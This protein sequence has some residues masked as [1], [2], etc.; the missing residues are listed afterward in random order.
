MVEATRAGGRTRG[1]ALGAGGLAIGLILLALALRGVDLDNLKSALLHARFVWLLPLVG[2]ALLS[3]LIRAWRWNLIIRAMPTEGGRPPRLGES[4]GVVM[5]GYMV[6]YVVPR[7]GEVARAGLL[8]R[9]TRLPFVGVAGTVAAER[10]FDT[11]SLGVALVITAFLLR[12]RIADVLGIF[13]RAGASTG[14]LMLLVIGAFA[15]VALVAVAVAMSRGKLGIGP[16]RLA[17]SFVDGLRAILL[18][19]AK[20]LLVLQTVAI[21]L[22]YW[23]MAYIPLEMLRL[24]KTYGLG[25]ADWWSIMT[26]GSLGVLVPS[27]GGLGT[28][29]ILTVETLSGLYGVHLQDAAAYAVLTHGIQL[30][31]YVLAGL[32]TLAIFGW[33][34]DA[35]PP[36][37]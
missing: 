19:P 26:I 36:A 14:Y 15:V 27:P 28:Y 7:F 34:A 17:R 10:A 11:L 25:P 20:T 8:S 5:V 35:D 1:I 6:N 2:V 9:R 16:A 18:V 3:H 37:A 22:C 32:I 31:A 29:H 21:W 33:R 12:S 24:P 4:F 30:L 23:V 13:Q